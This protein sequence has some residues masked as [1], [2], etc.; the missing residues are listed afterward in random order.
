MFKKDIENNAK[1]IADLFAEWL[2]VKHKQCSFIEDLNL[3]FDKIRIKLILIDNYKTKVGGSILKDHNLIA[4]NLKWSN[5]YGNIE[6]IIMAPLKR[7]LK[8]I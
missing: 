2:R 3:S 1:E 8:E 6:Y 7:I 4:R 5:N